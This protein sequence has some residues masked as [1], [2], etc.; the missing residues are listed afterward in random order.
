MTRIVLVGN[1]NCGKTTLFNA[2]T[3]LHQHTG[4]WPGVTVSRKSGVLKTDPKSEIVDLPGTYSLHPYTEEERVTREM[5]LAGEYDIILNAVDATCLERGLYLTMQLL[6]LDRPVVLALNMMDEARHR[7]ISIDVHRLSQMLNIPVIPV[8]ARTGEGLNALLRAVRQCKKPTQ[9]RKMNTPQNPTP[10]EIDGAYRHISR[11]TSETVIQGTATVPLAEHLDRILTKPTI[12]LFA[13]AVLLFLVLWLAF[14]PI[15]TCLK[16]AFAALINQAICGAAS[17]LH[18]ASPH[19]LSLVTD[20]ILAGVGSV[21]SFLPTI[22]LLLAGLSLLE[23]SGLMARAVW[24]MDRPLRRFGLSGRAFIPLLLGFGC[25]VPAAMAVRG[26]SGSRERMT[27]TMLLPFMSCGAKLPVYALFAQAFF[28]GHETPL[29]VALYLSGVLLAMAA[30]VLLTRTHAAAPLLMELPPYRLPTL[31]SVLR[32][33]GERAGEFTRRAFSIILLAT[34]AVWLM[35]HHTW[36]FAWTDALTESILGQLAGL[37]APIFAP[38]GFGTPA[39]SAALMTGVLAKESVISTLT[40]L[41][42][43]GITALFPS[44]AAALSFLTFVLLYT[45]CVAALSAMSQALGRKRYALM[46]ALGQFLVAWVAAF[47]VFRLVSL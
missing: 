34:V 7:A 1:Q 25:T 40:I 28:A 16:D 12:G 29:V 17:L 4:N 30:A 15:A 24:L 37:L 10:A 32:G 45:P 18:N 43:G 11:I 35:Q 47:C 2:L 36:R 23:D 26:M 14:G 27:T 42:P 38:L 6:Q 8:T 39:A 19:L 44:T 22:L 3:G 9:S 31:R 41:A 20:G 46:V 33:M 5:L 13:I 21:L